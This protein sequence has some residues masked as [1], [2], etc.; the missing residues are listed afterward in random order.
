VSRRQRS[1][2]WSPYSRTTSAKPRT[3]IGRGAVAG[4]R[5]RWSIGSLPEARLRLSTL[6]SPST[7][8]PSCR[9]D[10]LPGE[11]ER[12]Q[13]GTASD[14]NV[15]E[16]AGTGEGRAGTA[17]VTGGKR[18]KQGTRGVG[19]YAPA[20]PGHTPAAQ[21]SIP[22]LSLTSASSPASFLRCRQQRAPPS[23]ESR[24]WECAERDCRY[25]GSHL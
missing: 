10:D 9:A 7:S 11:E 20:G 22:G 18:S 21:E 13:G 15:A 8:T 3:D 16:G 5:R 17:A 19:E 14:E 25:R 24:M 1:S 6:I 12:R 4:G 2:S 23:P